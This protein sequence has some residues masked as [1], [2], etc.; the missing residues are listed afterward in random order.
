M[1]LSNEELRPKLESI[2]REILPVIAYGDALGLPV[3]KKTAAEI[4]GIY[5]RITR[6]IDITENPFIGQYPAGMWSDDTQLSLAVAESLINADGFSMDAIVQSH[7]DA[8]KASP[9]GWGGSTQKSVERLMTGK[10]W[11]ESGNV[12]GEGNGILMKMAPLV[13]WQIARG[14]DVR[15]RH[16]QIEQLTRM[17]HNNDLSVVTALVHADALEVL[18][19]DVDVRES[20]EDIDFQFLVRRAAEQ[21]RRYESMYSGAGNKTSHILGEMALDGIGL[22]KERIAVYCPGGGFH[23]P[24]T[25]GMVYGH[26]ALTATY[27][28][29]TIETVN[30][31][32]D[33]DSTGSIV[34]TMALFAYG[35]VE[36]PSDAN[37]LIEKG[38]LDAVSR[39]LTH[40]F[41]VK[42]RNM[43]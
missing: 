8:L 9:M 13:Y 3:E 41:A 43:L 21:A 29:V 32:G 35:S 18:A 31:G 12:K 30:A 25:L 10:K 37:L 40:C 42:L 2:G 39:E 16:E 5:G 19:I 27:P 1:Y 24:E 11:W 34:S 4:Q 38:K 17:T 15:E 36:L 7:I 28:E 6:L 22:T 23:S 26:L 14:I 33:T 20:L